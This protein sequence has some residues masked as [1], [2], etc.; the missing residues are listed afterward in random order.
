MVVTSAVAT[1]PVWINNGTIT[2]PPQIDAETFINNGMMNLVTSEP[3]ETASTLNYTNSGTMEGTPGW[4]FRRNPSGPGI[5]GPSDNFNNR[6]GGSISSGVSLYEITPEGIEAKNYLRVHADTIVN[7]GLLGIAA[8]G[9]MLLRG[10]HLDLSRG[11]TGVNPLFGIGSVNFIDDGL[12]LPD[13]AIDD[14]WWG[15]TNMGFFSSQVLSGT[16]EFLVGRAP[17]HA[18]TTP[19]GG[20]G[21][22]SFELINPLAFG[23]TNV[24][25]GGFVTLTNM[26]GSLYEVFLATNVTRQAILVSPDP[27]YTVDVRFFPSSNPTNLLRTATIELATVSTNIPSGTVGNA[28]LYFMD[29][30]AS[31]GAAGVLSNEVSLITDPGLPG[32]RPANYLLSRL[33][34][35]QYVFGEQGNAFVTP[36]FLYT[37]T[38]TNNFVNGAYAAY[39]ADV[40]SVVSRPPDVPGGTYT[41]LSGRVTIVA[42]E[43]LNLNRARIQANGLLTIQTPHLL[44]SAGALVN[45]E[46]L[47]YGFGTTNGHLHVQ[48]V[49]RETV[50]RLN[51]QAVAWSG[52]WT[53]R[54]TLVLTNN[55]LIGTNN[56]AT[57]APV[58]NSVLYTLHACL[59]DA[60]TLVNLVPVEVH[61][62]HLTGTNV[63]VDDFARVVKELRIAGENFTLNGTMTLVQLARDWTAVVAP[64]LKNFTNNG[65]LVIENEA[66]FGTDT[67]VPYASFVNHG[68][69]RAVGQNIDA[70]ECLITGTNQTTAALTIASRSAKLEGGFINS[71]GDITLSGEVFRLTDSVLQTSHRLNL[72]LSPTGALA[73]SG[74]GANNEITCLEGFAM[75]TKPATGDLLGTT[76]H[77]VSPP[78]A[79]VNHAWSGEDRGAVAAGYSNNAAIGVLS[80]EPDSVFSDFEFV[81]AGGG[82]RALYVDLLDLTLLP[83]YESRLY[84]GSPNITLYFAAAEG[85]PEEEL[86]GAL[87]GRLKWVKDF[88]GPNSSVEVLLPNGSTIVV[89][90]ALRESLEYDCDGDGLANGYDPT[91]FCQPACVPC[92]LVISEVAVGT[93]QPAQL[94]FSFVAQGNTVYTVECSAS[95][96]ADDWQFLMNVT[97]NTATPTPM[98]VVDPDPIGAQSRFYR[99]HYNP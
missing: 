16:G 49:T 17:T 28:T 95:G 36:N 29:T 6:L 35:F 48:D 22:F 11:G 43:S 19:G 96:K 41:N 57:N 40:D 23:Y 90:R 2:N 46:N 82:Q 3:F 24:V 33:P 34:T 7:R 74:E 44:S 87:G 42:E 18:V 66:H 79:L 76:I 4:H 88:V 26:D 51:G 38:F 37:N 56:T 67:A 13:I 25:S 99:V 63:M 21:L 50:A 12:F 72:L 83:D 27:A 14:L 9:E 55:W 54:E 98:S 80:L 71:I 20:G 62:Y 78:F 77:S 86:D 60:S 61:D 52:I 94:S 5:W 84:F 59:L 30:I 15:Q 45:A 97:N 68:V 64:D 91:P 92:N 47:S 85:V 81:A 58:T 65:T 75:P 70:D 73:D 69:I 39:A 1:D 32:A 8:G 10:K 53:N 89:N 93:S 31:E